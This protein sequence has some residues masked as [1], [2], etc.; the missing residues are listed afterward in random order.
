MLLEE[1]HRVEESV[2]EPTPEQLLDRDDGHRY[3]LIGGKLVERHMGAQSSLVAAR[4]IRLLGSHAEAQHLGEVFGADCG[5][6]IWPAKPKQVRFP[7]VSFIARS[8]LPDGTVPQGYIQVFP[9]LAV[10]AV[11]PSDTAEEVEAKRVEFLR[12]GTRLFWVIYPGS[13][14]IHAYRPGGSAATL[15]EGDELSGEDVLP[16][17]T[18]KVATL[19]DRL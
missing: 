14:T 7:D 18:C 10:E 13:R 4:L 2:P 15:E 19:F 11:S 3:E 9:D 8:R 5:Y 1:A 6:Q 16:G 12:A 17:F